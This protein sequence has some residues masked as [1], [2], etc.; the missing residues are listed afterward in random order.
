MSS[1]QISIKS[2]HYYPIKSCAGISLKTAEIGSKGFHNDRIFMV[3]KPDGTFITQRNFPKMALIKPV[4]N[5]AVLE[6]QT[7]GMSNIS[8]N[9][10]ESGMVKRV[11]IWDDTCQAIDQGDS[12]ADW[13][14]S[15]LKTTV[16]LVMMSKSFK[17]TLDQ[18]Y[19]VSKNDET[20]FADG[21][22]FLL[23]AQESLDN[24]NSRL[25][26]PITMDRFRPNIVVEGCDSYAED[27]WRRIQIGEI[28]FEVVKPC[29]R[30]LITT[31]DQKTLNKS[32]EP[33]TTLATY[34]RSDLGG[35]QFGQNLIHHNQGLISINDE[36]KILK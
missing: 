22:P 27:S 6:I 7:T 35:V 23:I 18:N 9:F 10:S 1:N 21:F 29:V 2:I 30:C 15:F 33:L 34:R 20:G 28:I 24:L 32:K 12:V 3:T 16:R 31:I 17:R 11:S 19:A 4:I 25:E 5:G 13:L 8:V 36:V 14:S 26:K